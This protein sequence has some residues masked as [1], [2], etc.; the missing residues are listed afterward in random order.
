MHVSPIE[1]HFLDG[2]R[3]TAATRKSEQCDSRVTKNIV[4]FRGFRFAEAFLYKT[5]VLGKKFYMHRGKRTLDK[6]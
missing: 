2:C 1:L 3:G 5:C 4:L 6:N